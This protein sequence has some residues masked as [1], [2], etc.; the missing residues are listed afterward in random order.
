MEVIAMVIP[1]GKAGKVA[2]MSNL[3]KDIRAAVKGQQIFTDAVWADKIIEVVKIPQKIIGREVTIGGEKL[4]ITKMARVDNIP[5]HNGEVVFKFAG[6]NE[7]HEVV[8]SAKELL[9]DNPFFI[10]RGTPVRI[11]R[12]SGLVDIGSI[13]GYMP[14]NGR[15]KVSVDMDGKEGYKR[16]PIEEILSDNPNIFQ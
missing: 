12:S 2:E 5:G 3:L 6:E 14:G 4:I 9:E 15:F 13:D 1:V 7:K 11:S 8:F 10:P 16:I